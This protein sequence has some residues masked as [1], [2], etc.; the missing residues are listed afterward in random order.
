MPPAEEEVP[1]AEEE[2]PPAEEEV[3]PGEEE[4]PPAEEE[5]P[6]G[7]EEVPPGDGEE[8]PPAEDGQEENPADEEVNP[9]EQQGVLPAE[10]EDAPPAQAVAFQQQTP[11]EIKKQVDIRISES[12]LSAAEKAKAQKSLDALLKVAVEGKTQEEKDFATSLAQGLGEAL[13]LSQDNTLSQEERDRYN[14]IARGISE[15]SQ[16]A[17]DPNVSD[18]DLL[19]YADALENLNFVITGLTDSTLDAQAK[20]FYS[21]YA[22][23]LLGGLVA[24][25]KPGTAPTN[26]VDKKKVQENLQKNAAALKVYQSA[27]SSESDRSAAKATLDEQAAATTNDQYLALVEELKR[28]KAPQACLDAVQTRTQQAGWPDGSLWGLSSKA[29]DATVKAGAADTS[30]DWAALFDC[31]LNEPFST[32]APRIPD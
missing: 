32:C 18:E 19:V 29:C 21:K 27:G 28:L 31:V 6:P 5:V 13:R 20:A 3:P 25:E 4:V 1:P 2:V 17:F 15:A 26:P 7:E 24:A 11:E 14:K 30:S 22:D 8:V 9:D 23:V 10:G 12:S 16:K